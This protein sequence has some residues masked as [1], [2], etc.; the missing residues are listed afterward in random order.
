VGLLVTGLLLGVPLGGALSLVFF[1]EPGGSDRVGITPLQRESGSDAAPESGPAI[2]TAPGADAAPQGSPGLSGAERDELAR[3][4]LATVPRRPSLE[5]DG[6]ITGRVSSADGQPLAGVLVRAVKLES[7]QPRRQRKQ[8]GLPPDETIEERVRKAVESFEREKSERRQVTTGADGRYALGSLPVGHYTVSAYAEGLEL[9]AGGSGGYRVLPGSTVDFVALALVKVPISVLLPDGT[10]AREATIAWIRQMSQGR[11]GGEELWT[12]E[13]PS[14]ELTEGTWELR[15]LQGDPSSAARGADSLTSDPQK[16][17]LAQGGR[18]ETVTFRLRGRPGIR[19]RVKFPAG[20]QLDGC[21]VSIFVVPDGS[22]PDPKLLKARASGTSRW[23]SESSPEFVFGDLLPGFYAVGASRGGDGSLTTAVAI[24]VTDRIVTQ[25][26]EIP[27]VSA[28]DGLIVRVLGSKGQVESKGR[29]W[30]GNLVAARKVAGD[31]AV[32]LPPPDATNL[33]NEKWDSRTRA[34]LLV[35]TRDHG[36]KP[37]ELAQGQRAVTVQFA[38]P[39][40]IAVTVA[41]YRGSGLEGSLSVGVHRER[42][43]GWRQE[44]IAAD[45]TATV[46]PLEAS[47]YELVLYASA[48]GGRPGE[49]AAISSRIINL[50][51]GEN[52]VT[53]PIPALHSLTVRAPDAR[54]GAWLMLQRTGLAT[55]RFLLQRQLDDALAAT[56][57]RLP[58]G[59]YRLQ[60]YSGQVSGFMTLEVPA[61]SVVTFRSQPQNALLVAIT[62]PQGSLARA[63]LQHRRRAPDDRWRRVCRPDGAPFVDLEGAVEERGGDPLAQRRRRDRRS[64]R[65]RRA[66]QPD[67]R[68]R[69]APANKPVARATASEDVA[70]VSPPRTAVP[71]PALAGAPSSGA[72]PTLSSVRPSRLPAP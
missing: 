68:G 56:F 69:R 24:E 50:S 32:V 19:G 64:R 41:G 12:A 5:G 38:A 26:I 49:R 10:A 37:V 11:M 54:S 2:A 17:E 22:K 71:R 33:L 51:G 61:E 42:D 63:G 21:H 4:A 40:S 1:G 35:Q 30:S 67:R 45:G 14:L 65:F 46:A 15:A 29:Q 27:P 57:E 39:A 9:R 43:G 36:T 52:S 13:E 72:A 53:L 8:G 20:E 44:S 62:D 70:A 6:L 23:I 58:A 55:S 16:I 3:R 47:S 18:V 31:Y 25:D 28:E 48:P 66:R 7:N 59:E 34:T 60:L